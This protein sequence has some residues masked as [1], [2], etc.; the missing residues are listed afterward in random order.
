MSHDPDQDWKKRFAALPRRERP[1]DCPSAELLST[2]ASGPLPA[3]GVDHL[4]SCDACRA[5]VSEVRALL[6]GEPEVARAGLRTRLHALVPRRAPRTGWIAAAAAIFLAALLGWALLSGPSNRP[7]DPP[8]VRPAPKP[9]PAPVVRTP[10]AE[11]EKPKPAPPA[12]GPAP[13]RPAPPELPKPAPEKPKPLDPPV[14]VK[15]VPEPEKPLRPV[16]VPE[17]P[18]EPTRPK[19]R[20]TLVA[21]M[22]GLSTQGEGEAA[23]QAARLAQPREFAG[24]VKLRGDAGGSKL[25]LGAH[26]IFVQRAA[27]IAVTLEE[28]RTLVRLAR[29]E[30]FFDVTPGADAFVVESANG[31]V[32]VKGTRFLVAADT[33]VLVQRGKVDLA[34]AGQTVA[35][36]AGERSA[37][38]AGKPPAPPTKSTDFVRRLAWVR[39]LEDY[40]P[41]EAEQ[42]A[43]Q[44]GMAVVPD[45][46]ASGGR[47]VAPVTLKP[48]QEPAAEIPVRRKQA[49]P[50]AIWVRYHW[51]HNVPSSLS[52]Q[53]HDGPK[54]TGKDVTANAAWQWVRV[55][56][57]DLPETP[58]RVRVTDATH[59]GRIDQL[60]VTSDLDFNPETDRR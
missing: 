19:L 22:G 57:M 55:G 52:V 46:A 25:R 3:E 13:E 39:A 42:M 36:S 7:A 31:T 17:K 1:A 32:T 21:V 9:Q 24:T 2:W 53:V 23:W 45:P 27:E 47:A 28:G 51:N 16:T 58:F 11:P 15:P 60:L 54:W 49:S 34:G 41:I 26:T 8:I 12:P 18:V 14:I 43:L 48:G 30:A 6:A 38:A 37:A 35:V 40:I 56:T 44:Q 20:A 59:G 4:A 29:G 33:E 10:P 50:Y 5:E